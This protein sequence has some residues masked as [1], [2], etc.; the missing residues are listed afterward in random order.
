MRITGMR[1]EISECNRLSAAGFVDDIEGVDFAILQQTLQRA[2]DA[3]VGAPGCG[4]DDEFD[5]FVGFPR[6]RL[7]GA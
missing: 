3:V 6:R 1:V 4:A 5:G 2:A 7:S